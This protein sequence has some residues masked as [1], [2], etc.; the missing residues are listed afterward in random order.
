M[1]DL[2]NYNKVMVDKSTSTVRVQP[3]VLNNNSF[4]LY[5]TRA[6]VSVSP[7]LSPIKSQALMNPALGGGNTIGIIPQALGAGLCALSKLC[8]T[9][10]DNILSTRLITASGELV[11]VDNS[12]PELLWALKG[13]GQH[14]RL[15]TEL[16]FQAYPLS[17]LGTDDGTIWTGMLIFDVSQVGEVTTVVEKMIEEGQGHDATCL[18]VVA[19]N[20][21]LKIHALFSCLCISALRGKLRNTWSR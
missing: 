7:S 10:S 17:I 14:F 1:I 9:T 3:G 16:T 19:F 8:G 5:T 21:V 15:V 18:A 11:T 6:Y 20:P 13:A 4:N 2:S 12:T